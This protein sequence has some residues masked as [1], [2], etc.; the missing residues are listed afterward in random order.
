[1]AKTTLDAAAREKRAKETSKKIQKLAE[2][3]LAE[4]KK[5]DN[6]ALDIPV[7]ALSNVAFN[8]KS[9][10]IELGERMQSREF[11][12]VSMAKKFM[13]TFL[14]ASACKQHLLET[15]KTTSIRDLYYMTKHTI[16]NT[17]ENTFDDQVESD[18]IIEDLEVGLNALRASFFFRLV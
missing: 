13:Q 15:G 4:L 8:E 18:P 17:S 11:F 14:V 6:P 16:R 7:R 1:M 5:Q 10:L 9:R 12:N 3:V 2:S